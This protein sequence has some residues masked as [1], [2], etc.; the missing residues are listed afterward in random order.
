[1]MRQIAPVP[2]D[3]RSE[4][5]TLSFLH[6]D[7]QDSYVHNWLIAGP[8]I[9]SMEG[10]DTASA[11]NQPA[12]VGSWDV[13]PDVDIAPVERA[14]FTVSGRDGSI[15]EFT[16]D[17]RMV[18]D[19]HLVDM[20]GYSYAA[21][22]ALRA[23]AYAELVSSGA[24]RVSLILHSFGPAQLWLNG[25]LVSHQ[26]GFSARLPHAVV[27]EAD[28][29]AGANG[30][31]VR[32]EQRTTDVSP[33]AIA[34]RVLS[35]EDGGAKDGGV[36]NRAVRVRLP[37]LSKK[38]KKHQT[39]ERWAQRAYF[40][41]DLYAADQKLLVK[42]IGPI[43]S[44]HHLM[45]RVE[46]PSGYII[47][48][49]ERPLEPKV[50]F[51]LLEGNAALDGSYLVRVCPEFDEYAKGMVFSRDMDVSLLH[52]A[53]IETSQDT[54]EERAG[55]LLE[56]SLYW[57]EG[58]YSEIARMA[59]GQ[60]KGFQP[61]VIR[62]AIEAATTQGEGCSDL[63]P[64]LLL[65]AYRYAKHESFPQALQGPLEDCILGYDY[66]RSEPRD[67]AGLA[68]DLA[69]VGYACQVL[70]GQLYPDRPFG[71]SGRTGQWQQQRG[72]EGARVWL[73]RRAYGGFT[74]WDS[75][76]TFGAALPALLALVDYASSEALGELA[77]VIVDK[78]LFSLAVHSFKG[79]LGSPRGATS[80]ASVI[81][82]QMLGAVWGARDPGGD[83][84]RPA[85]GGLGAGRPC[86]RLERGRPR[87]DAGPGGEHRDLQDARCNALFGAGLS[88][89]RAGP[90]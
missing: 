70:A 32:F 86:G 8:Q 5:V 29:V 14:T 46:K 31:L 24:S 25:Q 23:W 90:R 60:W 74:A 7:L 37:T 11:A 61:G 68:G 30:L 33:F 17:Y 34:L 4:S 78:L 87:G 42:W 83:R 76:E 48:H 28:M 71:G 45:V 85:G 38:A 67:D 6:Y 3:P 59:L 75:D 40:E 18:E 82:G 41:R 2:C 72:E 22:C 55:E 63:L 62:Q 39:I 26:D 64:G 19:D 57:T 10:P 52:S 13:Q 35:A 79:V 53:H 88:P 73:A 27:C 1:M 51:K 12:L 66:M 44:P 56:H 58:L 80:A 89:G 77:A 20:A 47:G 15:S 69:I 49:V 9:T 50:P 54:Y 81:D 36:E 43:R 16:W 21:G 84:R 65:T